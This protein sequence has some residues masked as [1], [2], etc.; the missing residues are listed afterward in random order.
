MANLPQGEAVLRGGGGDGA[1][2]LHSLDV[3]YRDLLPENLGPEFLT[4]EFVTNLGHVKAVE[5]WALASGEGE[6][7]NQLANGAGG[8]R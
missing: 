3:I 8:G 7:R 5:G 6:A 4:P 2:H 1:G